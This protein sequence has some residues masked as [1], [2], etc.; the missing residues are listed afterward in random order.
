[1]DINE[2]SKDVSHD[3]HDDNG[4]ALVFCP[5]PPQRPALTV[6]DPL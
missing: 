6:C 5:L 1:M 4:S 3:D 2:P